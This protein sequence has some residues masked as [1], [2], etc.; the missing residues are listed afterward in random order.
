LSPTGDLKMAAANFF[1]ALR[2]LDA[3]GIDQIVALRLP[4]KGLGRT[5]NNRLERAAAS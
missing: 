5:I 2:K 4:E 3:S 1:A